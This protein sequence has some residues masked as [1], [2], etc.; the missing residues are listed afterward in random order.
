M[1]NTQI[2]LM[3]C[4]VQMLGNDALNDYLQT[5]NGYLP[6]GVN[7]INAP[8][9]WRNGYTGKDITIAVIDTGCCTNHPDLKNNIIGGKNFT[10]ENNGNPNIYDDYN[11]HGTHICGTI[12]A[13]GRI[14][15]VAPN[16]K[17]LILK[18]LNKY[19]NGNLQSL[20]NAINYAINQKVDIISMSLGCPVD[21]TEFHNAIK[22][23]IAND[24]VVVCAAGNSGDGN[25]KTDE[26][27][28]PAGYNEVIS[29]GAID[30]TRLC[31]TFTNSNKEVDCVA[32]GVGIVSTFLNNE[33][34]SLSGTSMSVPHV[35]GAIALLKQWS[36]EEFGR[37]LSEVELYAQLIKNTVEL[38][39]DRTLQGNGMVF[40][41]L[42]L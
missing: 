13:N 25:S 23:A 20:V 14:K 19:G 6:M 16:A 37:K 18:V 2:K 36:T 10:T 33:Y 8:Y 11:G 4:N 1:E 40:L 41:N 29:V 21:I 35:T 34:R 22:N 12:C 17:L 28:Y 5:Q 39:A 9:L 32:P 3:N 42:R 15:G 26:Y 27:D 7:M 31:A 24:I 38:N 30:N